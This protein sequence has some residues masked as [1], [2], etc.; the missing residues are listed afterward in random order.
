[1]VFGG[2]GWTTPAV[3]EINVSTATNTVSIVRIKNPG[4]FT[5]AIVPTGPQT[6]T[7]VIQEFNTVPPR[8]FGAGLQLT[9]GF[10]DITSY[11][12]DTVLITSF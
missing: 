2:T 3:I 9:L 6:P 8:P 1:V 7:S 5:G 11:P 10:K 4:V 12:T